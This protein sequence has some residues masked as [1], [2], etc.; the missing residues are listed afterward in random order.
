[1][2]L[3]FRFCRGGTSS[4]VYLAAYDQDTEYVGMRVV[5]RLWCTVLCLAG[6]V[7]PASTTPS[8]VQ[9]P[10][11]C[12]HHNSALDLALCRILRSLA[13]RGKIVVEC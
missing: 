1:M 12:A 4:S 6:Q 10:W 5:V 11:L 3:S 2:L 13:S 7:W 9:E 8:W